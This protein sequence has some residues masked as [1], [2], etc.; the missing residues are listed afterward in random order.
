MSIKREYYPIADV[1]ETLGCS[2]S[3]LI[4]LAATGKLNI[5]AMFDR[6]T[7]VNSLPPEDT[8]LDSAP[9]WIHCEDGEFLTAHQFVRLPESYFRE[10]EAGVAIPWIGGFTVEGMDGELFFLGPTQ[11]QPGIRQ[12]IK[13]EDVGR[14]QAEMVGSNASG[15]DET[16]LQRRH[17]I[18]SYV[19]NS[20]AAG[21]SKTEAMREVAKQEGCGLDNIKRI[22]YGKG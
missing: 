2:M 19:D 10:I 6:I 14:L 17:R 11:E 1:V 5:W 16:P 9:Q 15:N 8:W 3:D 12:F 4:H 22:Y 18:Q 21:K 7:S 20:S 13:N